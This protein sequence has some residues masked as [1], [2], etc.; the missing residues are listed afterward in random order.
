VD[1]V[2]VPKLPTRTAFEAEVDHGVDPGLVERVSDKNFG[3]RIY[4]LPAHGSRT[5][6][7]RF[8][9]PMNQQDDAALLRWPLS[10]SGKLARFSATVRVL[11]V[12]NPPLLTIPGLGLQW[13]ANAGGYIAQVAAEG[14]G[15]EGELV[16][17]TLPM[18]GVAVEADE[19]EIHFLIQDRFEVPPPMRVVPTR[20]ALLW[21]ASRSRFGDDHERE[22]ALLE[23]LWASWPAATITVDLQVFRNTATLLQR[24]VVKNGSC[25]SLSAALANVV[26]DGATDMAAMRPPAQAM[27]P[28]FYLLFSDGLNTLG[29]RE[30]QRLPAPL[31]ALSAQRQGNAAFLRWLAEASGGFYANLLDEQPTSLVPRLGSHPATLQSITGS[32][33]IMELLPAPGQVV[34]GPIA[35]SGKLKG[36]TGIVVVKVGGLGKSVESRTYKVEAARA[37]PGSLLARVWA[38]QKLA[39]LTALPAQYAA[40]LAQLGQRYGLA[41]PG[42]SMLVLESLEQYLRYQ[43]RPP[44]TLPAL[45]CA[46]DAQV[47]AR[48]QSE[49]VRESERLET[50]LAAWNERLT[51]W[52]EQ[53]DY[54]AGFKF[55]AIKA[56][57]RALAPEPGR[58]EPRA[59]ERATHPHPSLASP[60][61]VSVG[62]TRNLD[63]KFDLESRVSSGGLGASEI[64][65]GVGSPEAPY[66][67]ALVGA[68]KGELEAVYLRQR[69]LYGQSSDFYVDC[70]EFFFAQKDRPL[71]LRILSNIA[72]LSLENAPLLRVLGHRLAQAGELA[73]GAQVFEEVLRLR[74]EEPQSYRDLALVLTELKQYE[75]ALALL[76][77][78][79]LGEWPRFDGIQVVALTELNALVPKARA[80]GL[81]KLP[82]DP[83]LLKLLDLDVRIV[84]SWDADLTDIDLWV[85]EPSG[86]KADYSHTITTIGGLVSQD[87]TDGY[88]PE[89]YLLRRAQ[90]GTYTVKVNFFGA[91]QQHMQGAVTLIL[92]LYTNF[93]RPNE[94]RKS[95]T[96]RLTHEQET[97]TIGSLTF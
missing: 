57:K 30:P 38:R 52:R 95:L 14:V 3:I 76:G 42:T 69:E 19:R 94:Q 84:L 88:G 9:T 33:A 90:K 54:P 8:D 93:G 5:I 46:Y 12:Q 81:V 62:P 53:Y 60:G 15:I 7:V 18:A 17:T 63:I 48:Q 66:L 64:E 28:D 96:V 1:A 20:I 24:F 41:T 74:P 85:V 40:A 73:L 55:R 51:W 10:L 82:I 50:V 78:V 29:T 68:A 35:L 4:P 44:A 43:I 22:V 36:E 47:V 16:L 23:A 37:R 75:R 97:L 86:E 26:Y 72:E 31:Y 58:S 91:S 27:A 92:D 32:A 11:D 89:E 45:R 71:A 25:P 87:V 21:D 83:R 70:A 13:V 61:R 77:K 59:R 80:A 34:S 67:R 79:V 49:A 6:A 65:L 56:A 39:T 2:V